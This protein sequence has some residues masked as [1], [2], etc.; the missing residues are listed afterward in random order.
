MGD[1]QKKR[2]SG[3]ISRPCSNPVAL[4]AS[5][6]F[7]VSVETDRNASPHKRLGARF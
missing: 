3:L 1:A 7:L 6:G 4:G 2:R 5:A